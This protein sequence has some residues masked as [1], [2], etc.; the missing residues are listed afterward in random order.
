MMHSN[1]AHDYYG[2]SVMPSTIVKKPVNLSLDPT[3]LQEA[4]ALG[5]NISRIAESG[6]R[7]AVRRAREKEWQRDNAP[8]MADY[9][10]WIEQNGLPLARHRSF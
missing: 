4:R 5:L 2:A 6:L 10:D 7:D 8:A 1:H 9:N 3:L